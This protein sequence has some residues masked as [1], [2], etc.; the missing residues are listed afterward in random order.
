MIRS[1]CSDELYYWI[2]SFLKKINQCPLLFPI[3]VSLV[4]ATCCQETTHAIITKKP[5]TTTAK[6]AKQLKRRE[7]KSRKT[8]NSH[9][10]RKSQKNLKQQK[11]TKKPRQ[12][13][14]HTWKQQI[15]PTKTYDQFVMMMY[16]SIIISSVLGAYINTW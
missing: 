1:K 2:V 6:K 16:I 13:R 11:I 4:V 10:S 9:K 3:H 7:N 8:H 14:K 12:P 5:K 15:H